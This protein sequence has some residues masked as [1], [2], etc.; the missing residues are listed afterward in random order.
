[1]RALMLV[2]GAALTLSACGDGRQAE[3]NGVDTLA[4]NNLI[5]EGD[6]A[7]TGLDGNM[8]MN[9]MTG[10]D[11]ATGLPA[12]PATQNAIQE[13]L[14]TNTPDTNLANGL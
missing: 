2:A 10:V 11:P 8:T 5:V 3:E 1:M 13:D 6:P 14:T 12:D 4:V 9:G 7:A